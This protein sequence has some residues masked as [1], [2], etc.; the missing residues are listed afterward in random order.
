MASC[1]GGTASN[2]V[3]YLARA[4]VALSVMM[5]TVSTCV[6]R[7]SLWFPLEG[8][9]FRCKA[10]LGMLST[11][12]HSGFLLAPLA[13]VLVY[14]KGAPN[15]TF[16]PPTPPCTQHIELDLPTCRLLAVVATPLLTKA[17]VG[18]LI[19][20]SVR[21]LLISTLQVNSLRP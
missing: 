20:V 12:R 17:L 15:C 18:A 5:T 2:L 13:S 16:A 10:L 6:D 3:T 1:P 7:Q 8:V 14:P 11:N 19:P 4:D 9:Q 21:G